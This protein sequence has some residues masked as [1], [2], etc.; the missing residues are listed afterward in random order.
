V[1]PH[2]AELITKKDVLRTELVAM[3]KQQD[4]LFS[5]RRTNFADTQNR[6]RCLSEAFAAAISK[7]KKF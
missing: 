5:G 6:N 7:I 1:L 3:Y 2:R 4:A